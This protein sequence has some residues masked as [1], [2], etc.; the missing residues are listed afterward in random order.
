MVMRHNNLRDYEA[1][2]LREV[3]RDVKVEPDLLPL[4]GS[5]TKSRNKAEKAR[6]DVSAVGIW[7]PMERTFLDVRVTNPNSASYSDKSIEQ[8]YETHE[9]EKKQMYNDRI[10]HVEKGSFTPLVFTTTGGMGP[11]A[12]KYHKQVARLISAKRNEEYSDVVNWIRT[13]V[14]FALLKSTLI[15]IRGDRGRKKRETPIAD[16]SLNLIPE[17]SS[18]EV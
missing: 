17:C 13:K 2:L 3:C 7:T 9:K 16:T 15:A 5:G 6:P 4:G 14:R 10:L 18:Y 11:E 1:T 12:T 8:I